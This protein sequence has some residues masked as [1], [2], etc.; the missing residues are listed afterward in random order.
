[1]SLL[2]EAMEK[3]KVNG[4]RLSEISGVSES[5]ISAIKNGRGK[6]ET[7]EKLLSYL[8]YKLSFKKV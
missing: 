7:L 8:D 6:V 4:K 1:M 5:T 2:S 3:K